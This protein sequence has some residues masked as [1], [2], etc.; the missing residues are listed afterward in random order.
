M[1][2]PGRARKR[3]HDGA[4]HRDQQDQ[5]RDL[6]VVDVVRVEDAA[7][8]LGV[9]RCSPAFALASACD[10]AGANRQAAPR[11]HQL[12]EQDAS[13]RQRAEREILQGAALQLREIDVEHHHDEQEQHRH[14]ADIDDDQDHRQEL[15]AQ[16]HEQRRRVEEG[17]DQEQHRMH[18]IARGDH[19]QRR[20]DQHGGEEIEG[21]RGQHHDGAPADIPG[22]AR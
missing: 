13:R 18:R 20:G 19:H 7:E 1:R 15:R 11:E 8:R 5:P 3:Q 14:R 6:E 22:N 10:A 21:E 17:E 16:Q 12:G 2:T 9:G 4:D